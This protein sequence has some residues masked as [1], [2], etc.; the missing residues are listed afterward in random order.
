[1]SDSDGDD[2]RDEDDGRAGDDGRDCSGA[3][4]LG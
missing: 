2:G 3:D 1:M 4:I